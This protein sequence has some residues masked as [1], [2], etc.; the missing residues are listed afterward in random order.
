MSGDRDDRRSDELSQRRGERKRRG[1]L[2][3]WVDADDDGP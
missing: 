1:I 2:T 3:H